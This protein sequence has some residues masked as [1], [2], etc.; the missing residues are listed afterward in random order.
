MICKVIRIS[1]LIRHACNDVKEPLIRKIL[2]LAHVS[3]ILEYG[4]EIWNPSSK[5][6]FTAFKRVQRW[7]TRFILQSSVPYEKR[8]KEFNCYL[9]FWTVVSVKST[10]C[11]LKVYMACLLFHCNIE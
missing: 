7:A 9:V 8:L 6:L 10:S 2:Y 4:S 3:P 5:G 11:S 1:G